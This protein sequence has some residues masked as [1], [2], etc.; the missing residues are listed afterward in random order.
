M[1]LGI[2]GTSRG[3]QIGMATAALDAELERDR[4]QAV[5]AQGDTNSIVANRA[6]R[7]TVVT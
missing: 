3:V 1:N 7:R 5:V 2:G 4:P 6:G